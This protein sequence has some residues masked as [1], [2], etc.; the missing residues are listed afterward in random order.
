MRKLIMWQMISVDGYFSGP[1]GELDWF[2]FEEDLEKYINEAH[3][4]AGM[5][6]YGRATYE[7][8]AS[9]WPTAKGPFAEFMN[10]VPKVVFSRTLSSASWNNTRVVESG[11]AEEIRK[12]K[13]QPGKDIFLVGSADLSA[14]VMR[15]ELVDEYRFGI[16]PVILGK[17]VPFFKGGGEKVNLKLTQTRPL[18]SGLVVLHYEPVRT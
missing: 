16:N 1:K 10:A 15:H 6:I 4:I 18:K 7:G 17:G 8:M 12:L 13:Q 9:Y 5:F 11:V 2:V 14:T 3:D